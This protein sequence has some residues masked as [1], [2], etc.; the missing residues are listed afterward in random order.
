M[1]RIRLAP[2]ALLL[3]WGNGCAQKS[4]ETRTYRSP[5][6]DYTVEA[7]GAFNRPSHWF[8]KS[9]VSGRVSRR[10]S[11]AGLDLGTLHE[12]DSR[13]ESFDELWSAHVW[14]TSN[15]L[16]F[17]DGKQT[18]GLCDTLLLVNRTD[19]VVSTVRIRA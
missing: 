10:G 15:V 14:Q 4:V 19:A 6:G 17:F 2:L 9:R 5:S 13:D 12:S 3:F 11:E 18:K 8:A 7:A 16:H 1:N